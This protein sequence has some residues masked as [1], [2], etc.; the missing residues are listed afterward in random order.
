LVDAVTLSGLSIASA[1]PTAK[2]DRSLELLSHEYDEQH[3][4]YAQ[5]QVIPEASCSKPEWRTGG[6]LPEISLPLD[7]I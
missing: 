7:D 1:S 5:R 3:S 4:C 2:R 6:T